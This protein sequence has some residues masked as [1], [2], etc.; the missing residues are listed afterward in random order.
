MKFGLENITTLCEALGHPERAFRSLL[1]AGT[2]G[3]GSVTVMTE[4][5]LRAAGYRTARYTSPHLVRLE[6][7]FVLD[8]LEV[9]SGALREAA[10]VVRDAVMRLLAD[11]RFDTPPTFF[12]CAT[13]AAFQ[14]FREHSI[15]L[16]VLEVGLG[17]RLD[18][19]NVVTPIATAITSI[20]FDH[21][22]QLGTSIASIAREKAGI[23]KPGVPVVCGPLPPDAENVIRETCEALGATM[24]LAEDDVRVAP[25]A[26]GA[27]DLHIG[28][29]VVPGVRLALEG[30]HQRHN[31]AVA[32]ALIE[33]LQTAAIRVSDEAIR[34]SLTSAAWPGRIEHFTIGATPVLLDAAHNP[35]GAAALAAYLADTGWRDATLVFGA[36][37]DKDVPGMLDALIR[38]SGAFSLLLCTTAPTPRAMSAA[39]LFSTAAETV[40]DRVALGAIDDPAAALNRARA[41]GRAIVVAGS[42]FL[43]GPLRDILR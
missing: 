3:K 28:G 32:V 25:R 41:R 16:A 12:E 42:I 19:T 14:L 38:P 1:I 11:G 33:Q 17:G 34:T 39:E 5:A 40:G 7:R 37:R 22:E 26:D 21:Q 35:A 24:I 15:D 29:R 20:A 9:T 2:N 6:E 10:G 13:A 23:I 18:A 43:L 4:G 27:V 30:A 8:G 31:A 36:M